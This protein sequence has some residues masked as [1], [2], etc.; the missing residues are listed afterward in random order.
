MINNYK[1]LTEKY[2]LSK[3]EAKS[4]AVEEGEYVTI[5]HKDILNREKDLHDKMNLR[6]E[7]L[8]GLMVRASAAI[9]E[10]RTKSKLIVSF[11][12]GMVSYAE[13]LALYNIEKSNLESR[14][15]H[16]KKE[17]EPI[18]II[19]NK[20]KDDIS[21]HIFLYKD[22]NSCINNI[23]TEIESIKFEYTRRI[24]SDEFEDIVIEKKYLLRRM[25]EEIEDLEIRI[26][27]M[28]LER[29]SRQNDIQPR[30]DNIRS[31]ELQLKYLKNEA[32]QKEILGLL[33]I[34]GNAIENY[35][36]EYQ[37]NPELK[38]TEI[39]SSNFNLIQDHEDSNR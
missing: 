19:I 27:S 26:A 24:K 11:Q 35:E 4:K 8:S 16:L 9:S 3:K 10:Y 5:N 17:M 29:L 38:L 6:Q 33:S 21:K 18:V 14:I 2:E 34:T 13:K 25:C 30:I 31:L 37:K 28:E 7:E 32:T 23:I 22:K 20:V 15:K 12:K 36:D 39:Q 1:A